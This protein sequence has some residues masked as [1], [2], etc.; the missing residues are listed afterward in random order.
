MYCKYNLLYKNNNLCAH[1][2]AH[3]ESKGRESAQPHNLQKENSLA[4]TYNQGRKE[5]KHSEASNIW[6]HKYA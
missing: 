5:E 3:I 2:R 1:K 4:A 6:Q